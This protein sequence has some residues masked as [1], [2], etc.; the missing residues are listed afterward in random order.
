M[1]NFTRPHLTLDTHD[2]AHVKAMPGVS[3]LRALEASDF[4]K[5]NRRKGQGQPQ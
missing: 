5:H 3:E 1:A 4:G 2:I